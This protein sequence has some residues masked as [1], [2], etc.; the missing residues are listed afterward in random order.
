[1]RS[2]LTE[3]SRA[4]CSPPFLFLRT[5][6]R[7]KRGFLSRIV[8]TRPTS[9]STRHALRL[10]AD[11]DF[12]SGQRVFYYERVLEIPRPRWTAYDAKFYGVTM[13]EGTRMTVQDRGLYVTHWVLTLNRKRS[14]KESAHEKLLASRQVWRSKQ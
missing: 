5:L 9:T 7:Q 12:D 1:M 3:R 14:S 10:L 4:V 11:P 6:G 13:P 8:T 2:V